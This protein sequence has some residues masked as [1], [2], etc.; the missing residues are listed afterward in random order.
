LKKAD[1][2]KAAKKRIVSVIQTMKAATYEKYVTHGEI[3]T[4]M[5]SKIN[6]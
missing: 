6:K 3:S 5:A 2:D 4:Y 1:A